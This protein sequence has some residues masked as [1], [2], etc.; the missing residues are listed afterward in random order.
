MLIDIQINRLA[1]RLIL[2]ADIVGKII[3]EL[4]LDECFVN[5]V[6]E[7]TPFFCLAHT[8]ERCRNTEFDIK[9]SFICSVPCAVAATLDFIKRAVIVNLAV[10]IN[11]HYRA[12]LRRAVLIGIINA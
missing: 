3:G 9:R 11:N 10:S 1:V 7:K 2:D 6:C 5:L 8:E 4:V 12:C